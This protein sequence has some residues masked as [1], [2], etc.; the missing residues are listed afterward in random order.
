MGTIHILLKNGKTVEAKGTA[1]QLLMW[2]QLL[3]IGEMVDIPTDNGRT[4]MDGRAVKTISCHMGRLLEGDASGAMMAE[5]YTHYTDGETI[6]QYSE[7]TRQFECAR[8]RMGFVHW[9]VCS[10]PK[11]EFVRLG[12][13]SFIGSIKK[14]KK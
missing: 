8:E 12:R 9:E 6:Y 1:A 3:S 7:V 13:D 11:G 5:P 14:Q 10:L 2:R 4:R